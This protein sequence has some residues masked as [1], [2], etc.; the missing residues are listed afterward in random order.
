ML[1]E[2]ETEIV[3]FGLSKVYIMTLIKECL[4]CNISKWSGQYFSQ[5][6]GLAMGQR[7]APVFAIC[8]MSR[9]ERPV[10][11]RLHIMYCRYIDDCC[12][13]TST[14][15]EMDGLFDILNR[16]SQYIKFTRDVPH[17]GWLLYLNTQI[18][19]SSG[20]YNVKWHQK[21]SSKNGTKNILLH[22][23]SAHPEAVKRAVVRNMYRTVTGVCTGEVERE[24]SRKLAVEIASL[25]GYG[26]QRWRSGS[27]A[28]SLRNPE[29]MAHLYQ[30]K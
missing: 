19:I 13:V 20:R 18:N 21:N 24:E 17:K 25:N 3:T 11:A 22:A 27:K 26:T 14:Q 1:D 23:K 9:V 30:T 12:V 15:Q 6:R 7:L 2:H 5:N 10:I 29:N 16:Q 8:F 4:N 28:Y